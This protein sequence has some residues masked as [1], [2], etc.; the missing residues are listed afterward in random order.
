MNENA[1]RFVNEDFAQDNFELQSVPAMTQKQLYTV[2]DRAILEAWLKDA[3][4]ELATVDAADD[5]ALAK[6]NTLEEAASAIGLDPDALRATVDRYNQLAEAGVDTDFG[7]AP[8]FLVPIAQAPFY[9]G[10]L[11]QELLVGIGG[12]ETNR[13]GQ[14]LDADKNPIAGLYA[15]GT[16]GCMLYRNIYTIN[17]GGTCNANNVNSARNAANHATGASADKTGGGGTAGGADA[18]GDAA[19]GEGAATGAATGTDTEDAA[20]GGGAGVADGGATAE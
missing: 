17:V 5:A 8:E 10:K 19:S 20:S 4:D 18:S 6:A 15:V 1:D 11:T 16:D 13:H 9:V 3:P 7:K 2:F 14:A 12:I